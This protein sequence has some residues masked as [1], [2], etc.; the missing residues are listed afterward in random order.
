GCGASHAVAHL[1]ASRLE[2]ERLQQELKESQHSRTALEE[3]LRLQLSNELDEPSAQ[4]GSSPSDA[5]EPAQKCPLE[6]CEGVVATEPKPERAKVQLPCLDVNLQAEAEEPEPERKEVELPGIVV[7]EL[8]EVAAPRS[9]VEEV[10]EAEKVLEQ[11][12]ALEEREAKAS[13]AEKAQASLESTAS[14]CSPHL[15]QL[16]PKRCGQCLGEADQLFLDPGDLNQYCRNCWEEYYGEPPPR[17]LQALVPTE[18]AEPWTE[19][20][21]AEAWLETILP[22]WPPMAKMETARWE[23]S[24]ESWTSIRVRLRRDVCGGHAREQLSHM[25]LALGAT[26]A[27]RYHII[28][29]VGEGH[30]TKAYMAKDLQENMPVCVKRHR[31]LPVEAL[32]DL[33]VV[34]HRLKEV[35]RGHFFPV[36]LDAFYDGVGYTV[37]SMLEGKNCLCLSTDFPGF[38]QDLAKLRLVAF[39]ALSGLVLLD[40]AGVVHNDMK[41]D[42][43][44]WTEGGTGPRVKIVDFGCA[45]LDQR[46]ERGRNWALAEGGAGHLGKWAPEMILRL[47]IGHRADVWGVAV[48]LCELFCGRM[49]WRSEA[50]SAEVV[51]AQ[52]LG[53][54]NLRDGL[55]ASLLRRSPLDVRQL[56]TPA[57][58]HWP[59]RR[60]GSLIEA[61]RPKH[62]GLDQ[63]LGPGWQDSDKVD[64]GQMLLAGLVLD[65]TFRPNAAQLLQCCNFLNPE[66]PRKAPKEP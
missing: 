46:E 29:A 41:P 44:I 36:L 38:F 27:Q 17:D 32:G 53:L 58:R 12:E 62:W 13:E 25:G 48:S 7:H 37:E 60:S 6:G 5:W 9:A 47:P 21:L 15:A 65:P 26:L 23:S 61:L 2:V 40:K 24:E 43:L 54:C 45:R 51:M 11:H 56:Y 4:A 30:F 1:Q 49:V 52:A 57:P 50:D 35:D 34:S 22:G 28:Q 8:E 66:I 14:T 55:P 16:Q 42:N 20:F 59:L 39:G 18:A 3:K 31:H 64:L 63:V 33:Y 19:E 10:T